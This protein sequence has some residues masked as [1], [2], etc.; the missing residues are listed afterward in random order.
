MRV[1]SFLCHG[2]PFA[3]RR[4]HHGTMQ[5]SRCW[6]LRGRAPHADERPGLATKP[7]HSSCTP[8][9]PL[10]Q[11]SLPMADLLA[12]A[13]AVVMFVKVYLKHL[14]VLACFSGCYDRSPWV[15][16]AMWQSKRQ[17]KGADSQT[18]PNM[19]AKTPPL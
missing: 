6:E 4:Y 14:M 16:G 15:S 9:L 8:L 17:L 18:A 10:C 19:Q 11:L 3:S 7:V 1:P 13:E 2:C 5:N 12:Q